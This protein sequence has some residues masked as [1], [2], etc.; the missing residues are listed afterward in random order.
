MSKVPEAN[1]K[2]FLNLCNELETTPAST[3]IAWC[4]KNTQ[5]SSV[6]TGASNKAQILDNLQALEVKKRLTPEVMG[7]LNQIFPPGSVLDF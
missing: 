6:I 7:L 4:T 1:L 2:K 5:V 3:A